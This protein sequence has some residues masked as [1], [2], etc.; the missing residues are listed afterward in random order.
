MHADD[1]RILYGYHF[2]ANRKLWDDCIVPLTDQQFVQPLDYSAGSI[3]NQVVHLMD[4]EEGWFNGLQA[5]VPEPPKFKEPEDWPTR[6]VIRAHW[7]TV[8]ATIQIYLDNLTDEECAA[9][10][11][12]DD[13]PTPLKKWQVMVHVLNHAT[14]HRAQTL[15]MLHR[16]GAPT[17]AQDMVFHFWGRL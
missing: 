9:D 2:A 5:T 8:E 1:I 10:F 11:T 4:V 3:R 14:D 15:S 12:D 6:E 17:F 16:L 7:E 13:D